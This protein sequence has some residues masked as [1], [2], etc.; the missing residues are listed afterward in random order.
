MRFDPSRLAEERGTCH[1]RLRQPDL[2][3]QALT[4]A[5]GQQLSARR[6][7]AVL[8]D[9][10]MVGVL[11]RDPVEVVLYG[12]AA[13]DTLRR[14]RSANCTASRSTWSR[15]S[16]IGTSAVSTSKS[17]PWPAPGHDVHQ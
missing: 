9:L 5:L 2:A 16:T 15:S 10:A 11:R 6:R 3:E 7:G 17:R 8:A 4:T 14:T 12:D 13:V 1:L